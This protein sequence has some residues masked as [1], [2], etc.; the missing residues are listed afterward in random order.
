MEKDKDFLA[1]LGYLTFNVRLKRINDKMVQSGRR[2]YQALK[3][4][5]EPNWFLIF[6]MLQNYGSLSIMEIAEKLK[7][8]H[9][10]VITIV[11]KMTKKGY[12]R[13]VPMEADNRK[14]LLSLTPKARQKLPEYEKVWNAGIKGVEK[15]L[16]G[17]DIL[18]MLDIIEERLDQQGFMER[19]FQEL[20]PKQSA[21]G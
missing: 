3:M 15:M 16:E 2:M 13:S 19:T 14:R 10:S 9:P 7:F 12:V 4:D 11:D 21:A 1:A 17:T 8:S 6:K 20:D 5:I 18:A